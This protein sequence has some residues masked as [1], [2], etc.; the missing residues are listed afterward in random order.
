MKLKDQIKLILK[1]F[2]VI[3]FMTFQSCTD[4]QLL[5]EMPEME[6]GDME[7]SEDAI[8]FNLH[9]D[10]D[11]GTRDAN[12]NGY[13]SRFD[14]YIDTQNKLR[15]FFFDQDGR[16]M[17]GAI[18]RTVTPLSTS[19]SSS[20]YNWHVRV[21]L[22]YVVDREGN[23]FDVEAIRKKLRTESFKIAVL[24]N[25]PNYGTI[26]PSDYDDSDDSEE[27]N[28]GDEVHSSTNVK[29]EPLWGKIHSIFN[30]DNKFTDSL[31]NINDL[32]HLVADGN[33]GD[34]SR[35]KR[36]KNTETYDFISDNQFRMGVKTDW[37]QSRMKSSKYGLDL[38]SRAKAKQWIWDYWTPN[39]SENENKNIYRHY[40]YLWF[41]WDFSASYTNN[42]NNF[43]QTKWGREWLNRNG[44]E[45]KT[46]MDYGNWGWYLGNFTSLSEK[47]EEAYFQYKGSATLYNNGISIA[48]GSSDKTNGYNYFSFKASRSG[49]LRVKVSGTSNNTTILR[50]ERDDG[51]GESSNKTFNDISGT[52]IQIKEWEINITGKDQEIKIYNNSNN[53]LVI[54]S[55]EYICDKYLFDTDRE[56]IMPSEDYPIPMYGVQNFQPLVDW[57]P[58]T[59][60]NLGTSSDNDIYLIRS[61]AKIVLYLPNQAKHVYMRSMNRTARCEPMDVETPTQQNWTNDHSLTDNGCEWFILNAHQV[62]FNGGTELKDPNYYNELN[63]YKNWL[64]WFYG[65]W[66]NA[67][68]QGTNFT[69]WSFMQ[70]KHNSGNLNINTV[71]SPHYFNPDINRSDYCEFIYAGVEG[72]QHKYVLYMPEK[73]K[74]DP[75]YPGIMSSLPKVAHIEYR[76]DWQNEDSLDDNDCYRI[77]FGNYSDSGFS[78]LVTG[79]APNR[80]DEAPNNGT[81]LIKSTTFLGYQWAIMRNHVYEFHVQGS[82]ESVQ[83]INVKVQEWGYDKMAMDW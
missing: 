79:T 18:D 23:Q 13:D 54:Y 57:E 9:L 37:V 65:S 22:N 61:L 46:W 60:Y 75:N 45:I 27:R 73:W 11:M 55:I 51:D 68:W 82:A 48:K 81:P 78:N 7:Y 70:H 76:Y 25:W 26:N 12:S 64:G 52:G 15:V 62:C 80:F 32:H 42:A 59:T 49:L 2:V 38:T 33:Y 41:L 36:P 47:E 34:P 6:I 66:K 35:D 71:N 72:G 44:S 31:K 77:Y 50:V 39:K 4:E 16:F 67:K 53:S 83:K 74:D 14:D 3:L 8:S 58:G 21:P 63:S 28:P 19:Q 30:D 43:E 56:G 29:G 1:V 17:F 5:Q 69:G 10:A 24:A 20:S 40:K